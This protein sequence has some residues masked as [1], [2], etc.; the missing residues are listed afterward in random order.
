MSGAAWLL[1]YALTMALLGGRL[2]RRLTSSGSC[3][4]LSILAWQLASW[5][6]VLSVS[7]AAFLIAVPGVVPIDNLAHLL[8]VCWG[9]L[10]EMASGSSSD[11]TRLLAALVAVAVPLR[12]TTCLFA[13]AARMRVQRRLHGDILLMVASHDDQLG[14]SVLPSDSLLAYCLPGRRP[15]V[16]ISRGALETLSPEQVAAVI[17]HE[18]GHVRQGHHL[19]V[20][21]ARSLA[22]SFP[23]VPLFVSAAAGVRQLIELCA[24]DAAVRV[25]G[26]L[27]LAR[28]LL[29]LS[30]IGVPSTALG[31]AGE[32][33]A[34]R[35][36][37]LLG[38]AA[39]R[40]RG[41][42][43]WALSLALIA[44]GVGPGIALAMPAV[45]EGWHVLT[46]CPLPA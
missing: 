15:R 5:S 4:R 35:I 7:V 42:P 46:Y 2:V 23:R 41:R 8:R 1:T 27:P 29:A 40:R 37:R 21:A 33:T 10:H 9:A 32:A 16:V 43:G 14:V 22:R 18:R 13:A 30:G 38:A 36:D 45:L 39:P 34:L 12:Y 44:L 25:H 3:P 24:D 26:R 28:A 19:A 31:G 20:L 17:A 11:P 6:V